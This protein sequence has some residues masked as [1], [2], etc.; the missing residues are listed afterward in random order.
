MSASLAGNWTVRFGVLGLPHAKK[1]LTA[2][3]RVQSSGDGAFHGGKLDLHVH[4]PKGLVIDGTE[5]DPANAGSDPG[6]KVRVDSFFV[7]TTKLLGIERGEVVFSEEP[8]ELSALDGDE[9]IVKAFGS[10]STQ[11]SA[12]TAAL[13]L[14]RMA[15]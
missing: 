2:R 12:P 10:S 9:A 3:V 15:R 5:V 7:L 4:V 13:H 1:R 6:M 11:S 8:K 14:D